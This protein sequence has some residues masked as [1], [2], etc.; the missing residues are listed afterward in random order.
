ML[1]LY[2]KEII[3]L[4]KKLYDYKNTLSYQRTMHAASLILKDFYSTNYVY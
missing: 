2:A 4:K 1:N 3:L